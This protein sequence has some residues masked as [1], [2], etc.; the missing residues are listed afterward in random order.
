MCSHPHAARIF[1]RCVPSIEIILLSFKAGIAANATLVA[2]RLAAEMVI[3]R[4]FIRHCEREVR[5]IREM[6]NGR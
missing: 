2:K 6:N 5:P 3:C 4:H 1:P